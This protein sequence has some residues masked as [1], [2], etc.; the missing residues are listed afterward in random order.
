MNSIFEPHLRNFVLVFM[1]DILV[2]SPTLQQH[3]QHLQEVFAVLNH[4][5]FFLK[6]S[7]CLFAQEQLEYFGHIINAK[8]V[9][10]DAA[11][12]RAVQ[13]WMPNS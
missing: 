1:D 8:E 6:R 7:K 4:H 10:T 2:Y 5:K 13:Q 11:K 12:I 9:A 3:L